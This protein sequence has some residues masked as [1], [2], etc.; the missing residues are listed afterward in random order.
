MS[1]FVVDAGVVMRSAFF[2][3]SESPVAASTTETFTWLPSAAAP[4]SGPIAAL[5]PSALGT[6]PSTP[7][8][9]STGVGVG[10]GVGATLGATDG[11]ADSQ[12]ST[13]PG[14][15]TKTAPTTRTKSNTDKPDT[16]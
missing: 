7:T 3:Y 8:A 16:T 11:S 1:T 4:T 14:R 13:G 10:S 15:T 5:T 2:A 12:P 6:P 9:A